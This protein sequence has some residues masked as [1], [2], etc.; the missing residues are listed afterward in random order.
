MYRFVRGELG[1]EMCKGLVDHPL[2]SEGERSGKKTIGSNISVV[3]EAVR[4]GRIN[5]VV[6]GCLREGEG[7]E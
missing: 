6:V 4:D 7:E 3:Y 2:G 1:V 5:G